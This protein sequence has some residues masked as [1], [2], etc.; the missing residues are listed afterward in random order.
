MRVSIDADHDLVISE[1]SDDSDDTPQLIFRKL[2][3]EDAITGAVAVSAATVVQQLI[4]D[5]K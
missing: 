3:D 5:S 4:T 1:Y 2:D